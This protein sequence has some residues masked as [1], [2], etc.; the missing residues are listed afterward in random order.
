MRANLA[1]E[2]LAQLE[3]A[4]QL[5]YRLILVVGPPKSGKTTALR[6]IQERTGAPLRN[7][8]LELSRRML[9]LTAKQQILRIADLLAEVVRMENPDLVLL[10][11]LE[12]LFD[13][14]LKQDPLRL[15]LSQSR[16][17]TIVAGWRGEV[18]NGYLVYA[19]PDHAEYRRYPLGDFICIE[20]G[21]PA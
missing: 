1:D 5:Y 2:I 19:K 10:D 18:R 14:T 3:H 9:D 21:E 20:A 17:R 7:V 13:T 8:N 11:N 12:L 16:N 6:I 4:P 15:L